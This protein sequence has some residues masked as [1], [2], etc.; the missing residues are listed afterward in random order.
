MLGA[1]SN[2]ARSNA[3]CLC[4]FS[5]DLFR[6]AQGMLLEPGGFLSQAIAGQLPGLV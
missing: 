4:R 1:R 5:Q 6:F 3:V 2:G